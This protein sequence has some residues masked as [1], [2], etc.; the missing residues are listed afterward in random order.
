MT[1]KRLIDRWEDDNKMFLC[2]SIKDRLFPTLYGGIIGD[3][4]GVPVEFK[5][6]GTFK[7]QDVMGYGTYN[8]PPGTWSDDTSL[9][10]CMVENM[11]EEGNTEHLM[12]KFLKYEEEGYWTPFGEMFDIGRTTDE[13]NTRFKNGIQAEKCGGQSEYDNGNGAIMRISPLIFRLYNEFDFMKKTEIIKQYTEITH[14]HAR[15]VVGSIIYIELLLRLYHNNSLEES[16]QSVY[17]LFVKTFED[18]HIFIKELK[19]YERIFDYDFLRTPQEDIQSGGYV[20]DTLE[21]AIWC[22]GNTSSFR[23]AVLKAVN[24]GEDTDTVASITGTLAGMY[25]KMDGIPEEWLEKIVRKQDIDQLIKRFYEFC[26]NQAL[27]EEY[28][29]L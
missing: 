7:V 28:G 15:A 27:I 4:M 26:A 10:L 21:A 14:A 24:L 22:L 2:E 23:D 25:Y 1:Y 11:I 12:R 8:Q 16:L 29:G 13:A 3:L 20:V 19:H 17:N 5:K 18:D 9:T 6:R